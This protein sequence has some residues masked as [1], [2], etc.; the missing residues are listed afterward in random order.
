[1][2]GKLAGQLGRCF[3]WICFTAAVAHAADDGFVPRRSWP[4]VGDYTTVAWLHGFPSR[5]TGERWHRCVR[6]GRYAFVLD[7]ETM[8]VPHLGRIDTEP[9][10]VAV[11]SDASA[12]AGLP[13]ADLG[14]FVEVDETTYRCVGSHAWDGFAGPRLVESGRW[15]QRNDVDGLRFQSTDGALLNVNGR[16][17]VVAWPDR[18]ALILAAQ[19]G[20]EAIAPGPACFGRVGGGFGFDGTNEFVVP[21]ADAVDSARFT[22]ECWVYAPPDFDTATQA[23]PWLVCKS[24]H[25]YADGHYGI[26]LQGGVPH[27]RLNIGGGRDNAFSVSVG[28]RLTIEAWNHIALTYD[29]TDLK[30][31]LN[32]GLGGGKRIERARVATAQRLVFGRRG[33]GWGDGYHFKGAIDEVAV[34]DR[35]LSDEEIRARVHSPE[36]SRA[37]GPGVFI[38][39][40][41][42]AGQASAKRLQ[43]PWRAASMSIRLVSGTHVLERRLDLPKGASATD[44]HEVAVVFDPANLPPTADRPLPVPTVSVL[45][46]P[47]R[48]DANASASALPVDFDAVRGWHRVDLDGVEPA[49]PPESGTRSQPGVTHERDAVADLRNDVLDRVGIVLTNASDEEQTAR[50]C[51]E[52]TTFAGS[53][54]GSPITGLSAILRDAAGQPTGIPVQLSKNWHRGR[55]GSPY[56]GQWFHGF[57]QVRLPPSSAVRLELVMAYGHWGGVPAASHAQ[58]SLLGWGKNQLWEESAM[59]SWGESM[60]YE[61]DQVHVGASILDVRPM[62]A[63]SLPDGKPWQ[64]TGNVGGGD[65]LRVEVADGSRLWRRNMKAEYVR[66][67]P[68]LT[69]VTHAGQLGSAI[70]HGETVSMCRTDDLV[71]TTYRLRM[72]VREPVEF[73][74]FVIFQIGAD[75]YDYARAKKIALGNAAGLTREWDARWGGGGYRTLP[76]ECAG[77]MPW[78]SLHGDDTVTNG[79]PIGTRGFVIRDW[80]AVL[81]GRDARP[82]IAEHGTPSSQEPSSTIDL[83]P[84]PG[85]KRLEPGDFIEATIE[86]LVLPRSADE[87]YG[88]NEALRVALRDMA[89][90]WQLVR[91]EAVG[92][93]RRVE[94][95]RGVLGRSYPDVRINVDAGAAEF[96]VHGGM[97]HMPLTFTGLASHRVGELRIDGV[98][99]DQ[100]VHGGD[101]WQTDYDPATQS[102]SQTFTIPSDGA[103][104]ADSRRRTVVF[105]QESPP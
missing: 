29:G 12:I 49:L 13:P 10:D 38:E 105:R 90:S 72:D 99:I 1:M 36:Q 81:G 98:P 102:W 18:I 52:K 79:M 47:T 101:Y 25:E 70:D 56:D 19:P 65:F 7:T 67:G 82:W 103:T 93:T 97:G 9:Y 21:A 28:G 50:L 74:R 45:A 71:R 40:F 86:F 61:P 14:L 55:G 95:T 78:V 31:F 104:S 83:V 30:I 22:L 4:V 3:G 8:T 23:F 33:D 57:T 11:R 6:T 59:G 88:P 63:R 26:T 53:R 48:A 27:G 77:A 34:H 96:A 58:L 51:F 17:E 5:A 15:L 32:G 62:L 100:S 20:V 92:N 37:P 44:W 69:E 24:D 39:S 68:C 46:V 75:T 80:R 66:P 94:V 76:M 91:R 84:P 16:F 87:Y 60:C 41:D 2:A 89:N 85:V 35:A 42:P 73:S 54:V 43:A 64:W